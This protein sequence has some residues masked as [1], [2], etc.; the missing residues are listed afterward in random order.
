MPP[1][2]ELNEETGLEQPHII[3]S[4]EPFTVSDVILPEG[5]GTR[6]HY[7][8]AQTFCTTQQPS[9][10]LQAGDDA[11]SA[12]W[13]SLEELEA[14]RKEQLCDAGVLAVLKRAVKL[15]SHGLL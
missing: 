3:F 4:P 5:E 12:S 1:P 7:M 2:T 14:L 15:H 13:L 11:L 10:T 6:F 8:I 9:T